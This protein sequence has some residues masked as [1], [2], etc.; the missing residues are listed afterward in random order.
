LPLCT[1]IVKLA[2]VCAPTTVAPVLSITI[3]L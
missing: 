3:T 1:G 2:L